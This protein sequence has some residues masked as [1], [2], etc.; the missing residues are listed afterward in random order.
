MK[1]LAEAVA[2]TT[3]N[4]DGDGDD[5][6]DAG[7]G[8]CSS[9]SKTRPHRPY[10]KGRKQSTKGQAR[11]IASSHEQ[12]SPIAG[13]ATK[14]PHRASGLASA[15]AAA[16]SSPRGNARSDAIVVT[17]C[18]LVAKVSSIASGWLERT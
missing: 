13:A 4:D 1:W 3:T 16:A 9:R 12:T 18:P 10:I 17:P 14:R 15:P 2:T 11:Q 8:V 5:D 6:N 7:G